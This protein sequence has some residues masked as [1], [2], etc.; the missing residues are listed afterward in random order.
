M[1]VLDITRERFPL[2]G[3][4]DV[5]KGI[6][7]DL[8]DCLGFKMVRGVPVERYDILEAAASRIS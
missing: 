4:A 8:Q 6:E 2:S 1:D 3:F 5:L 7:V